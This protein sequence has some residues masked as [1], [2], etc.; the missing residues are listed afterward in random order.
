[1]LTSGLLVMGI[2]FAALAIGAA[3][4]MWRASHADRAA[5]SM[6][7]AIGGGLCGV[8]ALGC[9]AGSVI[10]GLLWGG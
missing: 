1:M 10:L 5:E 8:A 4:G 2:V 7:L 9:F 6:L 3:I